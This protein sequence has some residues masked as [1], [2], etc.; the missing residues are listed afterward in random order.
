[1]ENHARDFFL[2][3]AQAAVLILFSLLIP[4]PAEASEGQREKTCTFRFAGVTNTRLDRGIIHAINSALVTAE[5][6]DDVLPIL[7]SVIPPRQPRKGIL[8]LSCRFSNGESRMILYQITTSSGQAISEMP[9]DGG[10]SKP[11]DRKVPTIS[12]NVPGNPIPDGRL[13]CCCPADTTNVIPVPFIPPANQ[14][15][16]HLSSIQ[17]TSVASHLLPHR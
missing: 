2:S 11:W 9:R 15:T 12:G 8:R 7:N 6:L 4:A 5:S 1:M 10:E 14:L 13:R 16:T 3:A 17:I